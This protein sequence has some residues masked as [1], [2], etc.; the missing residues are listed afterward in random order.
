MTLCGLIA[1]C[2]S[3]ERA[4]IISVECYKEWTKYG[5]NHR[6]LVFQLRR[7]ERSDVW[8]RLDRRPTAGITIS[9]LIRVKGRTVANDTVRIHKMVPHVRS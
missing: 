7:P 9:K 6:F 5:V 1:Q 3:L 8:L 4:K 2:A